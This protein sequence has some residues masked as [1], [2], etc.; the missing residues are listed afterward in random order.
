MHAQKIYQD[1]ED[2]LL[3]SDSLTP[4]NFQEIIVTLLDHGN[5]SE[6]F[7]MTAA[8]Q[9]PYG[10][11][12]DIQKRRMIGLEQKIHALYNER[13]SINARKGANSK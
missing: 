4:S 13:A 12:V 3:T 5:M 11:I 7:D 1:F 6:F 9:Y 10:A 2:G 8:D